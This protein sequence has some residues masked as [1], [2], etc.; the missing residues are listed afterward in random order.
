MD[1][2][3]YRKLL[4]TKKAPVLIKIKGSV[5]KFSENIGWIQD[6][7]RTYPGS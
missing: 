3:P 7:R 1:E 6:P 2:K 5:A 4:G